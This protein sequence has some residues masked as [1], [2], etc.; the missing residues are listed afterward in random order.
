MRG[1]GDESG[2][3]CR[4][5]REWRGRDMGLGKEARQEFAERDVTEKGK[6]SL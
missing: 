3:A 2:E 6:G 5:L 1:R 4:W